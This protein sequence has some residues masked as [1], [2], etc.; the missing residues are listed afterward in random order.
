MDTTNSNANSERFKNVKKVEGKVEKKNQPGTGNEIL[1]GKPAGSGLNMIS[2]NFEELVANYVHAATQ[3]VS[4]GL[5][6][7][8]LPSIRRV[9]TRYTKKYPALVI[10]GAAAIG[11][12]VGLTY[13]RASK[14]DS[15]S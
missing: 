4:E 11:L 5:Q 9:A 14:E 12:A 13:L 7:V 3:K 1:N 6:G 2:K 10:I 15:R 8:D